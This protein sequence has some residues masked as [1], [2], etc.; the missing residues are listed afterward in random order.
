[1]VARSRELTVHLTAEAQAN[2]FAAAVPARFTASVGYGRGERSQALAFQLTYEIVSAPG[3]AR[4][5]G[6]AAGRLN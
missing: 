5:R 4:R 6:L 3:Q 1:M 2:G